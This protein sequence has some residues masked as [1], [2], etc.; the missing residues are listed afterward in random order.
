MITKNYETFA[1]SILVSSSSAACGFGQI[2]D[3]KNTPFF[4]NGY[5]FT[6]YMPVGTDGTLTTDKYSSG[7]SIGTGD[8]PESKYSNNLDSTIT[9][10]VTLTL[11]STKAK[12]NGQY[13]VLEFT[14]TITNT[15]SEQLIVK[16]VG[17]KQRVYVGR[18]IG[19]T[20]TST[21]AAS[22]VF[23][24]DRTV[25]TTPLTIQAGDAGILKYAIQF[26]ETFN[27][28]NGIDLIPFSI[29][30]DQ[31]IAT[32]IDAARN[33]VIDLQMDAGWRVGDMRPID[34]TEFTANGITYSAQTLD[35]II[36][37]FGDYNNCGSLFQF[38]FVEGLNQSSPTKLNNSA[39][40]LGGY[41][42]TLAYTTILPAM[43]EALPEW[44]K[45]RLKTF[46][47]LASAGSQSTEI[48]TIPNNK[49]ALRSA[50]ELLGRTSGNA[51]TVSG[52]GSY[53]EFYKISLD[54]DTYTK[55]SA[56]KRGFKTISGEVDVWTRSPI[57][58][59]S[60][61]FAYI[62][63]SASYS[64]QP[65]GAAANISSSSSAKYISPFG[66]I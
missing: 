49:L 55:T 20:T 13:R 59:S 24:V 35:I 12:I 66:C 18:Y 16:E 40:N 22:I 63:N 23:L 6:N 44:L 7:I 48:E 8:S 64:I 31:Q 42:S 52:E 43:V 50:Y 1:A 62:E 47:V 26:T 25:L 65:Y 56:N 32:M 37:E 39:T 29:A 46:N 3:V 45:T 61:N 60:A 33:G 10:G 14:F 54:N 41:A 34:L 30:S 5:Y 53:I 58:N 4:I 21:S 38:D 27:Q 19:D 11:T 9:S 57:S 17:Y 15:G 28:K 36:T 2:F 51:S